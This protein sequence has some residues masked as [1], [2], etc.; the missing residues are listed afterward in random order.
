MAANV[1]TPDQKVARLKTLMEA[2]RAEVHPVPADGWAAFVKELLI[3]KNQET[4]LYAPQTTTG[5]ALEEAWSQGPA[6][7]PELVPYTQPIEAF[8]QELFALDAG[9]TS[10]VGAVADSGAVVLWPSKSE[11]R[12][13][14]LVPPIHIAVVEQDQ[15][16]DSLSEMMARQRWNQGM[17][18]NALLISGPSKTADIELTLAFGVHGPKELVVIIKLS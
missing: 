5:Q 8:K 3:E 6:G 14:S 10:T 7:T 2:V 13:M 1:L 12:L 16:Y 4:L 9:I 17:P 11:P 18:T 15:I